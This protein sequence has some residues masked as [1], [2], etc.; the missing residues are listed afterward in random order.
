MRKVLMIGIVLMSVATFANAQSR[1]ITRG[2]VSGEL[3]M[4]GY[5]Y[6]IY[7]PDWGPPVFDTLLKALYHITDYGKKVTLPYVADVFIQDEDYPYYDTTVTVP[8][9]YHGLWPNL[10]LYAH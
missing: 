9:A 4:S 8:A 3:Y 2:S 10:R 7:N 6:G 5:W 1:G